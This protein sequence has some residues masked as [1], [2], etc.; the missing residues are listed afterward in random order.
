[1]SDLL[2]TDEIR[3]LTPRELTELLTRGP[4]PGWD[5]ERLLDVWR[6]SAWLDGYKAG[7]MNGEAD[8]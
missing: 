4:V 8:E 7:F 5:T 2:S 6:T 1:M 3:A